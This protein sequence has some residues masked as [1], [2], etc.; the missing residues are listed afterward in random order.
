MFKSLSIFSLLLLTLLLSFTSRA[1]LPESYQSWSGL[2]KQHYL[3]EKHI[4]PTEYKYLPLYLEGGFKALLGSHAL[5]DLKKSFTHQSDEMPKGRL[6]IIHTYG[7][8]AKVEFEAAEDSPYTGVLKGAPGLVRL[9]WAAPPALAGYV[10]GMAM[11]F[12]IDGHPSVNIHV[13]EKLD[14][15]G[16]NAN[17][18]NSAFTNI[19]PPPKS[20]MLKLANQLFATAVTRTTHLALDH[21]GKRDQFGFAERIPRSPYQ[22]FLIP[23]QEVQLPRNNREDLR[24]SLE[25][26]GVGTV[27]YQVYARQNS[28]KRPPKLIG[29]VVLTSPFVSSRY[30]DEKLFF[31]HSDRF[32]R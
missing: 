1:A 29:R 21:L 22:I 4:K 26:F 24:R 31:Q 7:A 19:I 2:A 9:G 20:F 25:R 8:V 6:K 28:E 23:T 18:F 27:L 12:L 3:W 13:M 5:L 30:G 15:Q 11:K 17:F 14:G 10:P 16:E 32:V